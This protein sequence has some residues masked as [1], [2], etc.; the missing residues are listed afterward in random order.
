[1]LFSV[2]MFALAMGDELAYDM[3]HIY[4]IYRSYTSSKVDIL[5]KKSV[6]SPDK[7]R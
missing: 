4:R 2:S 3:G 6:G 7:Y 5:C 1:M